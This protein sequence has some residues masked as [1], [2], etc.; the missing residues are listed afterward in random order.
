MHGRRS[1][2]RTS[3]SGGCPAILLNQMCSLAS[4]LMPPH[5]RNRIWP[6]TLALGH[7]LPRRP[8]WLQ[9]RVSVPV[10]LT[11][12]WEQTCKAQRIGD[13]GIG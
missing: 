13:N 5:F 6:E 12:T 3:T 11:L 7:S 10:E 4:K 8:P 1:L 9:S 2:Q